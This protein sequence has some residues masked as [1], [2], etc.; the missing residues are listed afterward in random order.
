M[1]RGK[2][3]SIEGMRSRLVDPNG[4]DPYSNVCVWVWPSVARGDRV[5][6]VNVIGEWVEMEAERDAGT[7]FAVDPVRYPGSTL[8]IAP[9]EPFWQIE[10]RDVDPQNRTPSELTELLGGTVERWAAKCLKLDRRASERL[11][12]SMGREL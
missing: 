6:V 8:G 5:H 9:P 7:L 11:V 1:A 2:D 3:V 4:E 12:V 10:L